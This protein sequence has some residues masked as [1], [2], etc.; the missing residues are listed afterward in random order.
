MFQWEI[1]DFPHPSADNPHPCV[2]LSPDGFTNN[3]HVNAVNVL[4]CQSL[5]GRD[6]VRDVEV[7]LNGADGLDGATIVRCQLILAFLKTDAG[8]KRVVVTPERRRAIK[9]KLVDIYKLHVG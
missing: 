6:T 2:T 7:R 1:Y 9:R 4:A 3:P 5:R 8:R